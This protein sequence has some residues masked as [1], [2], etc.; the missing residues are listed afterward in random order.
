[1]KKS[2]NSSNQDIK[3]MMDMMK[4]ESNKKRKKNEMY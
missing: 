3:T 2:Q 1:M 4:M